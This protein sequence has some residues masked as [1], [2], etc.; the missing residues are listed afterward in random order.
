MT[1]SASYLYRPSPQAILLIG[2]QGTRIRSVAPDRPKALI[3]IAGK[4][5]LQWQIEWLSKQNITDIHLSAGY[6]PKAI[7]EWLDADPFPD[8]KISLSIE[9]RPLGTAGAIK[10]LENAI[11]TD[12]FFVLNG[13]SLLLNLDFQALSN[14][15]CTSLDA[16]MTLSIT[17]IQ[18]AGRYGT[19]TFN[20]QDLVTSFQEKAHH[21]E[22]WINGGVYLMAKKVLA[23]IEPNKTMSL[24][25]DIFPVLSQEGRLKAY[26]T[27]PPLLDMGTPTGLK[28][29]GKALDASATDGSAH[30]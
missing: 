29:M 13:D 20:D 3:S 23:S 11:Q 22:G 8:L 10:F 24:E 14:Q 2:G 21:T 7:Q 6:M 18:D 15:H 25:T 12:P 16:L 9:P 17:Q 1:S 4:P 28:E 5:F 26:K 19:V 30:H 27:P